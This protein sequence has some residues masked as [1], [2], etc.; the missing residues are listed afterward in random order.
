M[1]AI[2][3]RLAAQGL[4]RGFPSVAK[5]A[6][7][8]LALQGQDLPAVKW[9]L[10]VRRPGATEREV[11][12]AFKRG[13]IVRSWPLRGTLHVVAAEDLEW[14][15]ALVCD[16]NL[17][18][19]AKRH[20]DLGLSDADFTKARRIAERALDAQGLGRAELLARFEKEGL[21]AEGQRGVHLLWK[22]AQWGVLCLGDFDGKEQR[23][24]LTEKWILR[25]TQLRGDEALGELATRYVRGHGPSTAEDLA[26]WTGLTK[27]EA[28]RALAIAGLVTPVALDAPLAAAAIPEALLLPG[29][30][31]YFLGYADRS[32]VI[33]E[34]HVDRIVP[35]GNGIFQPMI[36]LRGKIRGTW[37]RKLGKKGLTLTLV[38]FTK[39]RS[40]ERTAVV[41]RAAE[42][43]A[44]WGVP[45]QSVED[46]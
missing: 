1:S 32:A 10:G 26:W 31:E 34:Q 46:A 38:P 25:S 19:H 18:R 11:D 42:L 5:V 35:G 43:A 12:E 36:V 29:F 14:L 30:D 45:L 3:Q 16:R 41:S 2:H 9:A 44:F 24:V 40:A 20:R 13:E 8:M 28:K 21:S 39:L 33:E 27:T 17:A 7:H 23:F 22:L 4:V 6:R 15:R 37:R